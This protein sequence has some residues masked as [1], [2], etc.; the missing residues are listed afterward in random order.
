ME[1]MAETQVARIW[2]TQSAIGWLVAGLAVA[3]MARDHLSGGDTIAFLTTSAVALSVA[4]A[5]F[6]YLIPRT[7]ANPASSTVAAKRGLV[8]SLLALVSIPTLFVGLPFVLG[9]GGVALG[10]LGRNGNR[11]RLATAAIV[12]GAIVVAFSTGWYAVVGNTE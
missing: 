1:S 10:L 6:A 7:K 3:A 5:V 2:S 8:C 9:G 12:I 4:A 11:A